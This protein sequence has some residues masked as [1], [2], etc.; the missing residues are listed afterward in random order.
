MRRRPPLK[1][2]ALAFILGVV[3][4]IGV[5]WYYAWV[6]RD[7]YMYC[8]SS[9]NGADLV[10]DTAPTDPVTS[11]ALVRKWHTGS[12]AV[13]V[14]YW[15]AAVRPRNTTND[16]MRGKVSIGELHQPQPIKEI[17]SPFTIDEAAPEFITLK[18]VA[19]VLPSRAAGIRTR[20]RFAVGWPM[21][22]LHCSN[23]AV[24]TSPLIGRTEGAWI[25]NRTP[26]SWVMIPY[27]PLP[28]GF[29][30]NA[31]LYASL[32]ATLFLS[33]AIMRRRLRIR[34]DLCSNCAYDLSATPLDRPCPECGALGGR[35]PRGPRSS[36][37]LT[38]N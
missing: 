21:Y 27:Y 11:I 12:V 4:T 13:H 38:H 31:A 6:A 20:E 32:W 8:W 22:A 17:V 5:A 28:M 33:V 19:G 2:L 23:R 34:R 29:A 26:T 36:E 14:T 30:V 18:P 37:S 3:T 24:S 1:R 7:G 25:V 10:P 9:E 35:R 15:P 16:D